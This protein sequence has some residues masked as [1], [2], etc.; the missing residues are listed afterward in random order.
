MVTRQTTALNGY[1]TDDS[2]K[3]LLYNTQH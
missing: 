3:W 1:S 2:I